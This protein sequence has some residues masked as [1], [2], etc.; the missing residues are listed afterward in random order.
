MA[1]KTFTRIVDDLTNEM[2]EEGQGE[3]IEFAFEGSS[4]SIDLSS[5]NAD[6]FREAISKYT[7]V[8]TKNVARLPR[9]ASSSISAPKSNKEELQKIREWAKANGHNISERGRVA[10]SVQDA[11]H[12]AH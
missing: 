5:K 12:A 10:Q 4:Y 9:A 1:K 8:A 6:D 7:D 3:T 2:L 11:Y